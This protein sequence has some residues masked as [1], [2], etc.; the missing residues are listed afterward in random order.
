MRFGHYRRNIYA[1]LDG[2]IRLLVMP[3]IRALPISAAVHE[4]QVRTLALK[5]LNLSIVVSR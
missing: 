2:R 1:S 4:Q 3:A 5:N